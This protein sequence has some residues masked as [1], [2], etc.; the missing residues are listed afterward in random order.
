MMGSECLLSNAVPVFV[1]TGAYAQGYTGSQLGAPYTSAADLGRRV[2]TMVVQVLQ[3]MGLG[4]RKELDLRLTDNNDPFS[5][6]RCVLNEEE[7][8]LVRKEQNLLIDF[9]HFPYKLIE[10]LQKCIAHGREE[11][12][13]Y[14]RPAPPA[15][16]VP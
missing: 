12:P 13:M 15:K 14:P 7:F 1:K 11:R 10:M 3:T 4:G 5:L 16:R 2:D 8:S 9:N 6:W